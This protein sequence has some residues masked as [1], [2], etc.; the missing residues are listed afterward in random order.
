MSKEKKI[1]EDSVVESVQENERMPSTDLEL[2]KIASMLVKFSF[3]F[4]ISFIY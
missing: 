3:F 1:Q 4:L 2:P